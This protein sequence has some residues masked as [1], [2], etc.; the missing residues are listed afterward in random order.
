MTRHP[1]V[2]HLLDTADANIRGFKSL[3]DIALNASE[4]LIALNMDVARSLFSCASLNASPLVGEK[5]NEQIQDRINAQGKTLEQFADYV[6]GVN[7]VFARTQTEITDLN[8]E[9]FAA[10][11]ETFQNLLDEAA[12]SGPTG[13]SGVIEMFKS[14]FGN[15]SQTYE[16]LLKASREVAESSV[17][18]TATALQPSDAT[19]PGATRSSKKAA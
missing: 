17:T 6:R 3:A 1:S 5:I 14:A 18:A 10:V 15:A 7:D 19:N 16:S 12:K 4:R 2:H 13:T 9:R 11:A 8:A